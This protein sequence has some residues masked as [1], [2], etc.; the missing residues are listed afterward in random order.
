RVLDCVTN[1]FGSHSRVA[2]CADTTPKNNKYTRPA[3]RKEIFK[4]SKEMNMELKA[5]EKQWAKYEVKAKVAE[6]EE[7][8]ALAGEE[9]K[10]SPLPSKERFRN[11]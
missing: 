2:S 1:C 7:N 11:C 10:T 6:E 9:S 4:S 3:D 8:T 5:V